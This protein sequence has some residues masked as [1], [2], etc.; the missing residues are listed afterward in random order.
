MKLS[1]KIVE[2]VVSEELCVLIDVNGILEDIEDIVLVFFK[3]VEKFFLEF[4]DE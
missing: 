3:K 2:S 4:V 1:R